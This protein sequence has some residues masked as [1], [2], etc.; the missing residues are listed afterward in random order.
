MPEST[1]HLFQSDFFESESLQIVQLWSFKTKFKVTSDSCHDIHPFES[2]SWTH[3][4]V[5][6]FIFYFRY[7]EEEYYKPPGVNPWQTGRYENFEVR[8]NR[9]MSY[10]PYRVRFMRSWVTKM[11]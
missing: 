1:L 3:M 2:C 8:Y 4:P 6:K 9:E 11:C 5:K 10:S 7:D